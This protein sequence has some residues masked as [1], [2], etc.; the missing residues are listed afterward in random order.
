[1]VFSSI[2]RKVCTVKGEQKKK[3]KKSDKNIFVKVSSGKLYA[4]GSREEE[5]RA[6]QKGYFLPLSFFFLSLIIFN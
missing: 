5:R 4:M 6:C 1:M 2:H 3:K